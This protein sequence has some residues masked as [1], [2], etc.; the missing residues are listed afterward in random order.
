MPVPVIMVAAMARNRVIGVDNGLPWHMRSDLKQFKAATMGKPLIMG[1]KTYQS[2][3]R[4][5]PGRRSI[6]VTRDKAFI[7]EGVEVADSIEAALARGQ[8][9][10]TKMGADA[11][12][13]AGGATIYEQALANADRLLITELDLEA[14][15]DAVFPAFSQREWREI[16]RVAFP[17]GE[18]DDASFE[19]VS[20]QRR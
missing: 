1:R 4:P 3:G 13:V 12:I 17:R 9:V 11:V 15:G 14:T 20:W 19:V 5:L 10:A 18:G 8:E 16:S 2:I 6:V 7:A